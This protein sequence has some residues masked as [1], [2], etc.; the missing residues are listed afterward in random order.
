MC[1]S[2][3]TFGLLHKLLPPYKT[4]ADSCLTMSVFFDSEEMALVNMS[5]SDLNSSLLIGFKDILEQVNYEAWKS[6]WT[7]LSEQKWQTFVI[8]LYSIVIIFGF[9]ANLLVVV[10]IIRY[11]QLHTV[12]NIYIC[13]LAMADVALCVF[14]LPIQL[15]YQLTNNWIF[16]R[17]LCYVTWPSF[18]VPLFS[19]SLSILMIAVDRYMLIV[20]PFKKRMS[21]IQAIFT[22][23]AIII[24]T[25]ALSTPIILS[26]T[27]VEFFYTGMREAKVCIHLCV[28]ERWYT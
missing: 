19:S 23:I 28:G 15:H 2:S 10:V 7:V 3:L 21:N 4:R 9:F 25:V 16:G 8:T 26:V 17:A 13:Y 1:S 18:G 20:Y 5:E 14:N 6:D 12:T 27:Y 11:R 24:F 22:V